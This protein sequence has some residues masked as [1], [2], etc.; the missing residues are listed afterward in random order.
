ME[1]TR[2]AHYI[3]DDELPES[4]DLLLIDAGEF[5]ADSEFTR[6]APLSKV[7][8]LD[9]TGIYKNKKNR[10]MLINDPAWE[11]VADMPHDRHGWIVA[12]RKL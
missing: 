12:K 4:I 5:G 1:A 10:S 8:A 9:D 11:V 3:R 6:L 2:N 7:I